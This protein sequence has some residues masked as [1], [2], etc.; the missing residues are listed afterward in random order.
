MVTVIYSLKW[1]IGVKFIC[2]LC[3]KHN[4]VQAIE[5]MSFCSIQQIY[6]KNTTQGI[7]LGYNEQDFQKNKHRMLDAI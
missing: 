4:L 6:S 3:T 5:K 7:Y 1:L 2:G